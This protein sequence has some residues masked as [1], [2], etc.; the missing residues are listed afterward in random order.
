[1]DRALHFGPYHIPGL[2]RFRSPSRKRI[3]DAV[4]PRVDS[5]VVWSKNKRNIKPVSDGI[6]A[7]PLD[8]SVLGAN[9]EDQITPLPPA[10]A[11]FTDDTAAPDALTVAAGSYKVVFLAFPL[12]AYGTAAQKADLMHRVLT[13]FG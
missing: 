2:P 10:T 6:G 12:E 3:I 11:A 1:M 8:H 13:Y 4:P 7:V 9:F 5:I